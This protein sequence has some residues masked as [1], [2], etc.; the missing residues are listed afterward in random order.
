[1]R[2][3]P[4]PILINT[5]FA[6]QAEHRYLDGKATKLIRDAEVICGVDVMTGDE[7]LV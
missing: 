1:M 7:F 4:T 2:E 5:L 6:G 3:L